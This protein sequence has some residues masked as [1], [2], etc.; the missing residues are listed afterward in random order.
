[1]NFNIKKVKIMVTVPV[2]EVDIIRNAMC[3]AG[4]GVIGNYSFCTTSVKS[5]GTFKG[6]DEAKPTI[7]QVGKI[8][9]VDE[10]KL[11]A[12]CDIEKVKEVVSAIRIFHSYEEPAIDIV[13]LLNED[14]F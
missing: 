5:T 1:M 11:E 8:E 3:N 9:Y 13:P 2:D 6:S 14:D 10:E 7:G 12:I 4:A